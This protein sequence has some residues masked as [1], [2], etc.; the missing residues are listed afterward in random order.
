MDTTRT[1]EQ[2]VEYIQTLHVREIDLTLERV[3]DVFKSLYPEGV[4]YKVIS[5]AGTNGKGSTASLLS[6]CYAQGG[7]TTGKFTSPHLVSFNERFQIN[8]NDVSDAELLASFQRVEEARDGIRLTFFEFGTLLAIDLFSHAGVDIGIMEVGLGGRLDAVNILDADVSIVTS[9]AI[10][11]TAWLGDT[12]DQIAMEKI[13]IARSFSPCVIGVAEPPANLLA[14]CERHSVEPYCIGQEF[15]FHLMENGQRWT[16]VSDED[17]I[18]DLPLP[19]MQKGVQLENASVAIQAILK[20]SSLPLA[21]PHIRAGLASAQLDARCQLVSRAPIVVLDVAHNVASME[22]LA[23]FIQGL[24]YH[25]RLVALCGMLADKEVVK[26]LACMV[27]LVDQWNIASIHHERGSSASELQVD[28][29]QAAVLGDSLLNTEEV[30]LFEH[31]TDAY[32]DIAAQ[33][34]DEDCLV[35]FGSFHIVGDIIPLFR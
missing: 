22:R 32:D 31:V 3:R 15:S 5:I 28:L 17:S 34:N 16:F 21:A 18:A 26:S 11:H 23:A 13:G 19:F 12:V 2:W 29:Q 6:S 1:L 9:L 10:D 25:G 27:S 35:V 4:S 8:G 14:Y 7:Y 33:L 30:T 24:N 20:L